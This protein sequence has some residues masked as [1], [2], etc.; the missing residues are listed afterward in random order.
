[1]LMHLKE[2]GEFIGWCGL[3]YLADE[4]QTDLGYRLLKKHWNKGYAT[5]AS[6][7]CLDYGFHVLGLKKII[8]R[9]M[10][11]NV[12]SIKIMQKLGMQ[13]EPC[14]EPGRSC[15]IQYFI[16]REEW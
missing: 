5:E 9:A 3:K 14:N 15:D 13:P 10:K 7:A 6:R 8:A 4:N 1:W 12:N 16:T 11:P 2:T